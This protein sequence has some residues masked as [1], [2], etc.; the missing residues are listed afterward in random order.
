MKRSSFTIG[1][2]FLFFCF[3]IIPPTSNSFS[4]QPDKG[5][6]NLGGMTSE[7]KRKFAESLDA[8]TEHSKE[9]TL[10]DM[11]RMEELIEKF[12]SKDILL[13]LSPGLRRLV[14]DYQARLKD[15]PECCQNNSILCFN[16]KDKVDVKPHLPEGMYNEGKTLYKMVKS[17]LISSKGDGEGAGEGH[18]VVSPL[19]DFLSNPYPELKALENCKPPYLVHLTPEGKGFRFYYCFIDDK[20]KLIVIKKDLDDGREEDIPISETQAEQTN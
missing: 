6:H 14:E 4:E 16:D 1:L 17:E 20:P 3:F 12:S 2:S 18:F 15:Y 7:D 11:N 19:Y 10:L 13:V 9:E 8:M 5:D